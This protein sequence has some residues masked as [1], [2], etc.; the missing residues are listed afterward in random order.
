MKWS[1]SAAQFWQWGGR[2]SLISVATS[3]IQHS[4]VSECAVNR[5]LAARQGRIGERAAPHGPA[6][7]ECRSLAIRSTIIG[8]WVQRRRWEWKDHS[9]EAQE[10]ETSDRE[11]K[12]NEEPNDCSNFGSGWGHHICR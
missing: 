7:G 2:N 4:A 11:E 10:S 12:A 8:P 3:F 9:Q 1:E 5:P 6:L